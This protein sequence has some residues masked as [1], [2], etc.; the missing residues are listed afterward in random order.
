M[1]KRM[2]IVIAGI[3]ICGLLLTGVALAMS[4]TNY[5][6]DWF[7]PLTGGGGGPA[8]STNYAVNLTVGQ[9][10]IGASSSTNYGG[11]LGYWCGEFEYRVLLPLVLRNYS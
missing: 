8:N 3:F 11:C 9:T 6:L 1:T 5:R 7:T 2:L 10:A 4:S